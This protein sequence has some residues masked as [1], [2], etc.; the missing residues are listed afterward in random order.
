[1]YNRLIREAAPARIAEG[2]RA[3]LAERAPKRGGG[4]S[5]AVA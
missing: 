1:M 4:G 5:R 2:A 3:V